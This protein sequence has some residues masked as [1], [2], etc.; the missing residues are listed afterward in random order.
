MPQIDIKKLSNLLGKGLISQFAPSMLQGVIVALFR[1]EEL[2][3][4]KTSSW[5]QNNTTLWDKIGQDRQEQL[6]RSLQKLSN[7]DFITTDWAIKAL[8]DDFPAVA[9]LFLGWQKAHNWLGRQLEI[10]KNQIRQ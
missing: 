6:K 1:K 5:V 9:S 10:I 8:K 7:I 4:S 3:V 2:D